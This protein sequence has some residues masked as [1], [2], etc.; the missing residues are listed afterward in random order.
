MHSIVH[1]QIESEG[2]GSRHIAVEPYQ[3]SCIHR[4]AS[5]S[6]NCLSNSYSCR[7]S[8]DMLA[9]DGG[10]GSVRAAGQDDSWLRRFV[11]LVGF[12]A[13]LNSH[14]SDRSQNPVVC[15]RTARQWRNLHHP[16][17]EPTP[18]SSDGWTLGPKARPLLPL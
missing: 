2:P 10:P 7:A 12:C 16:P 14:R 15:A 18:S 11:C 3:F 9:G 13:D 6:L 1:C 17:A 8:T 4:M 5:S